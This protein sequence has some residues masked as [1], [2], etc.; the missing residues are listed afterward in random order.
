MIKTPHLSNTSLPSLSHTPTHTLL[1]G[2]ISQYS[3]IVHAIHQS[4][5]HHHSSKWLRVLSSPPSPKNEA[6]KMSE[7]FILPRLVLF[8]GRGMRR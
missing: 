8:E 2:Q 7:G 3:N 5:L 6:T 4:K 1:E